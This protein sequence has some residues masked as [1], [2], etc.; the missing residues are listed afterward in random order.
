[1]N[2]PQFYSTDD[3]AQINEWNVGDLSG[4][5]FSQVFEGDGSSP[6]SAGFLGRRAQHLVD[7]L[8]QP[9]DCL[10]RHIL[11]IWDSDLERIRSLDQRQILVDVNAA[12]LQGSVSKRIS[13][14]SFFSLYS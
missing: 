1:M 5:D 6:T 9:D 13:L 14:S 3:D 7:L 10:V 12:L 8:A 4:L 2:Y 11:Q